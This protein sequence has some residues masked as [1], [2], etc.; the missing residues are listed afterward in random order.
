MIDYLVLMLIIFLCVLFVG[1][2]VFLLKGTVKLASN[3]NKKIARSG[4]HSIFKGDYMNELYGFAIVLG[5]VIWSS[6]FLFQIGS[7]GLELYAKL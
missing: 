1:L 6:I 2:I 3:L 4:N 5:A 7:L